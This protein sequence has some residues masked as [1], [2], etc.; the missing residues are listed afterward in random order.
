MPDLSHSCTPYNRQNTGPSSLRTRELSPYIF[1]IRRRAKLASTNRDLGFAHRGYQYQDLVTAYFFAVA[2]V[3]R[4]DSVTVDKKSF[5]D[6]RFDDLAIHSSSGLIRRQIKFSAQLSRQLEIEDLSTDRKDLR[7]DTLIRSYKSDGTGAADEYR[8]CATWTSATDLTILDI[9][10]VVGA[11]PSFEKHPTKLYRLRTDIVWPPNGAPVLRA[12]RNAPDISRQDFADFADRFV[13]ELECPS[14]SRD[15]SNPGPLELLLLGLL[16]NRIGIGRYP[17]Q[18]RNVVDLAARLVHRAGSARSAGETIEPHTIESYLQLQKDFGRVA[19]D[20]PIRRE[21]F[22]ERPDLQDEL[23]KRLNEKRIILTGEPGSGKS[24]ALTRLVEEMKRAGYTVAYHYCYLAPGD[25]DVERRITTNVL[26]ANLIYELIESSPTLLGDH[27]RLYSAG[28]TE[29]EDLL[30]RAT[31]K[32]PGQRV[33]LVVDGIDHISRVRSEHDDITEA[34]TDIVSKL[35]S[36]HLPNE[37]CIIIGSQPGSHLDPLF[38]SSSHLS[39]PDWNADEIATLIRNFDVFTAL[40]GVGLADI[41]DQFAA[42]LFERSEGN[43]LYATFLCREILARLS[44]GIAFDPLQLLSDVPLLEGEL[45]RYYEYL[46]RTAKF[47]DVSSIL[48]DL[49]GLIDFGLTEEE[50]KVIYPLIAHFIPSTLNHL[51]PILDQAS[52][53]GGIRIYHESFRRFIAERLKTQRPTAA[54][55]LN[56]L[57][58]WLEARGFYTDA[59]SYRF[60]L[61]TLRR[62]GR[63][64]GVL[65]LVDAHFVSSSV[66][67]GHPRAAI[68]ANI[69]VATYVAAEDLNWPALARCTEL[70]RAVYTCFEERLTE[71]E[72][73]GKTFAEIFGSSNLEERLLFDG[74]PTLPAKQGLLLC[75]LCDDAGVVPPWL[76]YLKLAEEPGEKNDSRDSEWEDIAV[77]KFHGLLRVEGVASVVLRLSDWIERADKPST[78]Y[79]RRILGKLAQ[80]GGT[81][82]LIDLHEISRMSQ[83]VEDTILVEIARAFATENETE[84]ASDIATD[85]VRNRESPEI[86]FDCLQLG[87]NLHEVAKVKLDLEGVI[88]SEQHEGYHYSAELMTRWVAEVGVAAVTAPVLLKSLTERLSKE[89]G[90]YWDWL[91]FVVALSLAEVQAN[92]GN[93]EAV[94]LAALKDLASDIERFNG[95]PRACDLYS[96]WPVIHR[97]LARALR[98]LRTNSVWAEALRLLETISKETTSRF[99]GG[100]QSGPLI[101]EALIDLLAPYA[102]NSELNQQIVEAMRKQVEQAEEVGEFYDVHANQEMYLARAYAA[103]GQLELATR[104]W[105]SASTYLAAYGHRKD[106]TI[107]ELIQSIPALGRS[108]SGT[109]RRAAAAVQPCVNAVVEHTDGKETSHSPIYW[110]DSLSKVDPVG[111]AELLARS[112]LRYGGTMDWRLEDSLPKAVD[113]ARTFANSLPVTLIELT[114]PFSGG[115][116]E[117]DKRLEAVEQLLQ[118]DFDI[119]QHLLRMLAAQVQGD[120]NK[121]SLDAYRRIQEVGA[122]YG[123]GIAEPN[124]D[125]DDEEIK[126]EV[127]RNINLDPFRSFRTNAVFQVDATPLDLM[128]R[129]RSKN[130]VFGDALETSEQFIHALGYRLVEL[131][132]RG[133][134]DEA[135]RLIRYYARENYFSV[136]AFT[137]AELAEG[138]ERHGHSRIAAI[139]YA[140][141]YAY[142]RGGHGWLFLGDSEQLPWF[143]HAIR[144]SKDAALK[145]LASEVA[146]FLNVKEYTIGITRHL[147]ELLADQGDHEQAFATWHSAFEVIKGRLPGSETATGPFYPYVPDDVPSWSVDE[148]LTSVLTARISHPELRRKSTSLSG[149]A[150]LT[151][152]APNIVASPVRHLFKMD[153]PVSS[154]LAILQLILESEPSPYP[155][156]REIQIELLSLFNSEIFGFRSLARSLLLRIGIEPETANRQQVQMVIPSFPSRREMEFLSIDKGERVRDIAQIWPEFPGLVAARFSQ[157]FETEYNKRRAMARHRA[158]SDVV[159]PNSP[160][161]DMLFWEQELFETAFHEILDSIDVHLWRTGEWTPDIESEIAQRV[162]MRLRSHVGYTLSRVTRPTALLPTERQIGTLR[163]TELDSDDEFEGWY[164]CALFERERLFSSETHPQFLGH[165][166]AVVGVATNNDALKTDHSRLPFG[167]G[168][169]LA[170]TWFYEVKAPPLQEGEFAGPLIGFEIV[171]GLFGTNPVLVLNPRL[172]VSCGLHAGYWPGR[173]ELVDYEGSPA[174]VFRRWSTRSIGQLGLRETA[175]LEGCDLVIRPD[176]FE[177]IQSRCVSILVQVSRHL[178]RGETDEARTEGR[179]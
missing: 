62:A 22:V 67:A 41:F 153:L 145:T 29:L 137:I 27:E 105:N 98:L 65:N 70:R 53:Q 17:N 170:E 160:E 110:F 13:I 20:F 117:V 40:D 49:L 4:Y 165:N 82:A 123:V 159:R 141:A 91:R 179:S 174:V 138:L 155:I 47:G 162:L 71:I 122:K 25:I 175:R 83:T 111:A 156:S 90:W 130:S 39:V 19:Q 94:I 11:E 69:A 169:G 21:I 173:L 129:L 95:K 158:A 56:P 103:G 12:L 164:R 31:E 51:D 86:V 163:V 72:L 57:I 149:L 106:I 113:A 44:S 109:A 15:F 171:D 55:I 66:Q 121:F 88:T 119:G 127:P 36:L 147:V 115:V 161:T 14:A 64:L 108:T 37:V 35:A 131:I 101:P 8:L 150:L 140:L 77:A 32:N 43:P 97:S 85:I 176:I 172:I 73:Y 6:D 114:M 52:T 126:E 128:V 178:H 92:S 99:P 3:H 38:P 7:I 120:A 143:M 58:H 80:L 16:V 157:M 146:H 124:L 168:Q 142:S 112:T 48:A 118:S 59:K 28:Q 96:I 24:W 154:A 75:S 177:Q 151:S 125:S 152:T 63:N 18:N 9:L 79:F 33:V 74:R 134:E 136:S 135:I 23:I 144:L 148:A 5:Q 46:L 45:P 166:T 132:S 76:E 2:L 133:E 61:P 50:L 139:A 26:F 93:V 102:A 30:Q 104:L 42:Q 81:D 78:T 100:A 68:E 89:D 60:L 87:A 34:E 167:E 84:L 116:S 107:Y 1:A 54:N 10:D